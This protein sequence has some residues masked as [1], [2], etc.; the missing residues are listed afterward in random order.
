M[1]DNYDKDFPVHL[2]ITEQAQATLAVD[3]APDV[4]SKL[5]DSGW[6]LVKFEKQ[7]GDGE[8]SSTLMISEICLPKDEAAG[9]GEPDDTKDAFTAFAKEKGVSDEPEAPIP[10]GENPEEDDD[11]DEEPEGK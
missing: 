9:G 1:K 8:G 6:A 5:P 4:A 3:G 10:A 2:P 11:E 7:P